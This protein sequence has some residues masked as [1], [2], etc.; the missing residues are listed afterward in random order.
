MLPLEFTVL[1][2][3]S[4]AG[5]GFH[6]GDR[7][8]DSER[9]RQVQLSDNGSVNKFCAPSQDKRRGAVFLWFALG[10][11]SIAYSN[12]FV[13]N[14]VF[15]KCSEQYSSQINQEQSQDTTENSDG[16]K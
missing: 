1:P 12:A 8:N 2:E 7:E 16:K 11:S 14:G 15:M 5:K 6:R 3:E 9:R 13:L 10:F 4:H